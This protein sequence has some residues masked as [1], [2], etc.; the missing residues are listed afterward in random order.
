MD[1][2]LN[3]TKARQLFFEILLAA[4]DKKQVTEINYQGELV[5]K[6]VPVEEKKFDWKA[7]EKESQ[8]ALKLLRQG[9]WQDVLTVRKKS[10]VRQ[11]KKW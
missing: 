9:D 7:Y 6:L 4:R 10:Q 2:S 5:A 3:A 8:R 1:I 11:Y